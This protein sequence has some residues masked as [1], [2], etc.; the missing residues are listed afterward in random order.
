AFTWAV[1]GLARTHW[2]AHDHVDLAHRLDK[3]TSGTLVLTKD[4]AANAFLKAAFKQGETD[5]EYIALCRGHIG[6]D[7]QI[8]DA[9]I[10]PA[11][12]PIRIQ[13]AVR[14]DGLPARTEVWVEARSRGDGPPMTR[15]RVRL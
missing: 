4:L 8:I 15:V 14:A 10:G 1:V 11:D 9:P 5:K 6:W 7:H 12:G 2:R 3:E 13:Q